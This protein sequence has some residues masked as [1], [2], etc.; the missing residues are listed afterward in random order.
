M[1]GRYGDLGE[2]GRR[3]TQACQPV[4]CTFTWARVRPATWQMC[5][6]RRSSIRPPTE[7]LALRKRFV[8]FGGQDGRRRFQ[9]PRN[10]RWLDLAATARRDV[11]SMNCCRRLSARAGC[12]L[13]IGQTNSGSDMTQ[14]PTEA[15]TYRLRWSNSR[16]MAQPP[17]DRTCANSAQVARVQ[18]RQR[19]RRRTLVPRPIATMDSSCCGRGVV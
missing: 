19:T 8:G 4:A 15:L 17:S 2:V 14:D 10:P 12:R 5:R 7:V 16:E 13:P 6:P 3:P 11:A 18:R 1:R 9:L